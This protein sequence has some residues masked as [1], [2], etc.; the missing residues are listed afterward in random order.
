MM[1]EARSDQQQRLGEQ[2]QGLSMGGAAKHDQAAD[3]STTDEQHDKPQR[4]ERA[5][6]LACGQTNAHPGRVAAHE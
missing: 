4:L 3:R 2:Q 5:P 1:G 6:P